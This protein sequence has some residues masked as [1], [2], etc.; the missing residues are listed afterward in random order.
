MPA[1]S[2]L[3]NQFGT[4]VPKRAAQPGDVICFKGRNMYASGIGHVGIITEAN[5]KE[6]YFIHASVNKGI[7]VD[8]LSSEYY[9]NRLVQ[10]RRVLR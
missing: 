8:K 7:T 9:R 1:S 5:P 4:A 10:I 6:I 2:S 3:Y